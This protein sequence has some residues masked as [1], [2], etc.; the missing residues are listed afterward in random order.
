[1]KKPEPNLRL[2]GPV[3]LPMDVREVMTSQMLN[4]RGSDYEDMLDRMEANVKTLLLTKSDAYFLTSSGTGAM[5]AGIVNTLSPGDSVLAISIGW[6]GQRLADI[7]K[8]YGIDV[9]LV[10][11]E[12]GTAADPDVVKKYVQQIP[13]LKAVLV[14]HN[15]SSTGVTNPLEE[16]CSVIR[17]NS[18][19]LII[20]DAVSSAGGIELATDA[21]GIDIIATASQKSWVAPPGI[22]ILTFS[23]KAWQFHKSSKCPSYYFDIEQYRD[24]L[25][26]G[27]P[28]FTPCITT[29][30][31]LEY[32][33]E[34]LVGEGIENSVARHHTTAQFV[35]TGI[36]S[37][38]LKILPK[39][40]F[41][42]NTVTAV[43]I[44]EGINGKLFLKETEE[45]YN[46]IFGGGQQN[47]EGKIFRIGHMGQVSPREITN[48]LE[49]A[50]MVI[51]QMSKR[52]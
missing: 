37:L 49:A 22:A 39:L 42:S 36:E 44:P 13:D 14:T 47:L 17:Q 18:D 30:F 46:V 23:D 8:A 27:Q 4:H 34:K 11:F 40:E 12:Q 16:I 6:F 35:R 9:T 19:C 29:M 20:V 45:K 38:S 1:M 5:E 51:D 24:Y 41:S 31:A 10:E 28:P 7:A 52:K 50:G 32:S 15:E 26:K 25:K 21:W 48:A 43:R 3:P 2:P 33:L